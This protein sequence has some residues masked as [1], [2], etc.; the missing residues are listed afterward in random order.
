MTILKAE[1]GGINNK[2]IPLLQR[3]RLNGKHNSP[4]TGFQDIWIALIYLRNSAM[5]LTRKNL[6]AQVFS[7]HSD[8]RDLY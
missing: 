4:S 2:L 3:K 5:N 1:A 7:G 8:M 6:L